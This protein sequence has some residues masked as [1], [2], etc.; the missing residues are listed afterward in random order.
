[1]ETRERKRLLLH[2]L[3]AVLPFWLLD[4][5]LRIATGGAAWYPL[6]A[7]A[8][9]LFSLGFGALFTAL[10][11][12]PPRRWGRLLYGLIYAVWA[13][14]AVMQYAVWRILDRVLF[15]SDFLFAGEGLDFAGYARQIIGCCCGGACW[16]AGRCPRGRNGGRLSHCWRRSCWR[17]DSRRACTRRCRKRWTGMH[18]NRAGMNTNACLRPFTTWR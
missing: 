8:P 14:Y 5:T 13:V 3:L 9:N 18:G 10:A 1:M 7:A 16:A 17:R 2:I 12:L 6:Y 11:L 15:L 4:L